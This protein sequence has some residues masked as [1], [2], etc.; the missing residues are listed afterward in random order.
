LSR[1]FFELF[2]KNFQGVESN[3]CFNQSL[4]S[5]CVLTLNTPLPLDIFIIAHFVP[6]VKGFS[7]FSRNFFFERPYARAT[8]TMA[9]IRLRR[10]SPLDILI[11]AHS[12]PF[13]K[14]FFEIFSKIFSSVATAIGL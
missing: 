2:Q 11:I 14:G 8:L 12:V 5:A 3:Y 1:G 4:R 7:T 9:S 6:F 13:V 10:P